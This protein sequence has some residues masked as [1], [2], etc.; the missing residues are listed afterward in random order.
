[1]H[2]QTARRDGTEPAPAPPA[3]TPQDPSPMRLQDLKARVASEQYVVDPGAVAEAL[4]SAADARAILAL[5]PLE[6]R[7]IRAGARTRPRGP[8][9][10]LP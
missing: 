8:A 3:V 6:R 9:L 5:P 7:I 1:M 10:R 2:G 4:L